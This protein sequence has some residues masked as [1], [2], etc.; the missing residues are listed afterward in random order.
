MGLRDV[1]VIVLAGLAS[2]ALIVLMRPLFARY[3]LARPNARSSH[4][5]PTP[6]GGGVAGPH[7]QH[8]VVLAG[9]QRGVVDLGNAQHLVTHLLPGLLRDLE[10][11]VCR[12]AVA[13]LLR[14]DGRAVPGD[15][16]GPLEPVDPGVGVGP[17]DVQLTG[18]RAHGKPAV[19]PQRGH[20]LTVQVVQRGHL[21]V[22]HRRR[23]LMDSHTVQDSPARGQYVLNWQ[24]YLYTWPAPEQ[25]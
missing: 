1:A 23:A 10:E 12:Q 14:V 8:D 13:V 4:K 18:Q 16:P 20:D 2:A 19:G 7:Q 17:G 22:S 11:H 5:A 9:H 21:S 6:Q 15:H 3:A 25:D 24:L